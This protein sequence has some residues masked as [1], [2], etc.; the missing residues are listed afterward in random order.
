MKITD[1]LEAICRTNKKIT[2]EHWYGYKLKFD[3][4]GYL[5][6]MDGNAEL[7]TYALS[8]FDFNYEWEVEE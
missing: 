7:T 8:E 3:R 5:I 4:N 1:A 6:L 2:R